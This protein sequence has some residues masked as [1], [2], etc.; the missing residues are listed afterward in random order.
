MANFSVKQLVN[1]WHKNAQI[2]W[3]TAKALKQSGKYS[4]CLFFCHL[5]LECLLK[6]LVC[7]KIK[8]EAPYI[9][10]LIR[11]AEIAKLE[12]SAEQKNLLKIVTTFN[13]RSRYHD[14]KFRFYKRATKDFTEKYY[15]E[16]NKIRLW[17]L[18]KLQQS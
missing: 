16:C 12:L 17:L 3:E 7:Q 10:N 18:K 5:V 11:L 4:D 2:K 8:K 1:Y 14:Y 9:H 6:S 15:Q 13:I